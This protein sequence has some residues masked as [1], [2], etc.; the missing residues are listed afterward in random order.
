MD[1]VDIGHVTCPAYYN[2]GTITG[3]WVTRHLSRPDNP[4]MLVVLMNLIF[5]TIEWLTNI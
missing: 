5:K 1:I 4:I 3:Y 2:S